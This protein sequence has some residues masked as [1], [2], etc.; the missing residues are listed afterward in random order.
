VSD[1]FRDFELAVWDND[2]VAISYHRTLSEVT[3]GCIPALIEAAAIT[4]GHKVL[5]VAC[6]AGYV[7]AAASGLGAEAIGVDSSQAQVRLAR[8]TYL[9]VRFVEG[10]AEDLP[11]GD[12]EFDA[13]L[14]AFGMLHVP[15]PHRASAEAYRVLKAAGRFA[16]ASWHDPTKCILFSMVFD[17]IREH[18]S[19]DVGLPAGP[20]PFSCGA[21]DYAVEMLGRA[22]FTNILASE[23]PLVWRVSSPN[24]IIDAMSSATVRAAAV[25]KRQSTEELQAVR[26]SLRERISSY[27]QDGSYA[28]PATACV[29]SGHKPR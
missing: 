9:D 14:N 24:I 25:L 13:V 18:G 17:A 6:G 16:Y 1:A 23:I 20:D 28:V 3:S 29:I 4:R 2:A 11:F 26:T 8:Q 5:D 12:G 10:D 7:A 22:G 19:L 15:N 21:V 27:E